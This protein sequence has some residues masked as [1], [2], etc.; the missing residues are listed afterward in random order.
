[1]SSPPDTR[2]ATGL[3]GADAEA[4][5]FFVPQRGLD[6]RAYIAEELPPEATSKE[7]R[8]RKQAIHHLARY[9]WAAMVLRNTR[10][11][12]VLDAGCG[13]GYGSS[14]LARALPNHQIVGGDYGEAAIAH[15]RNHFG[16][17]PN[18]RFDAIDVASWIDLKTWQPL[19]KFD[20]IVCFETIEHLL[21]REIA[22]VNFAENLDANGLLLLSTP[23]GRKENLLNPGWE[24][25]KIEYSHRYLVNLMRR[26]FEEVMIPEDGALPE[27][28]FW[29]SVINK[30]EQ[31]Y[32]LKGTPMVCAKPVAL[33]LNLSETPKS[34]L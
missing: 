32:L 22:L 16:D 29:E 11:G 33:G 13:G 21:H 30:G 31:R 14:M 1:V 27:L 18:L 25:N 26:F 8:L 10:P 23:S 7:Q 19:G 28:S 24:R 12:R 6:V 20:Y 5:D 4:A 9:T 34:G 15:A 3:S 2:A 17:I